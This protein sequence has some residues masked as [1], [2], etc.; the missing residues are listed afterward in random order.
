MYKQELEKKKLQENLK[1]SM[2]YKQKLKLLEINFLAAQGFQ[3]GGDPVFLSR[4]F[5]IY[6]FL[7]KKQ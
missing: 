7:Y 1:N 2:M 5:I 6:L 3:A 4:W